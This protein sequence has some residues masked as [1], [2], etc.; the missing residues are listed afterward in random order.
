MHTI[1][2]KVNG[3]IETI[4]LKYS[5]SKC[6]AAVVVALGCD[7]GSSFSNLNRILCVA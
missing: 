5:C 1:F 4:S 3:R 7:G 2:G 6:I